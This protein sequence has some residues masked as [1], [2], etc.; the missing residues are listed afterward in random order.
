[1][2]IN[3]GINGD[4][5]ELNDPVK[6]PKA[7]GFLWN[8]SMMINANCRGYVTSQFM[9]PEPSKYSHAPNLEANTFMQPE[10][11]Y[12]KHH[13]GRFFYIK[14]EDSGDIF[15]APYEPVRSKLDSY[16]FTIGKNSINWI[17][18]K[19]DIEIRIT[20]SL[21]VEDVVELWD[22]K[23]R[24]LSKNIRNITIYPYF[25]V[26]YMSWMN[27]SGI[28]DKDLKSIICSSITPYQKY[29]EYEKIK[30]LKDKTFLIPDIAPTSW[31]VNQESFEGDGG[32][33]NPD[34]IKKDF[35][36]KGAAKYETPVCVLQYRTQLKNESVNF[37]F[38]FGPA[39][40][41]SEIL[42]IK[43]KYFRDID[44]DGVDGFSRAKEEYRDYINQANGVIKIETPDIKFNNF[45]NHWLP[46]QIY[47]HGKT[48]R[49]TTDP[50]TRNYLQDNMGMSY[51]KPDITRSAIILALNQ[52][53]KSGEMPDGILIQKSAKLKYINQIPHTDHCVW[54]PI[55][56]SAYLD[57]T[58]D[59]NIL[60]EKLPFSDS[61][62]SRTVLEHINLA[63]NWLIT[64]KDARGLNYINQG[65][66]CDPMNMVGLKG[67]GVSGWLTI[68]SA[69][70]F[71]LWS[72]ICGQFGKQDLSIK[73]NNEANK[74]NRSIN[75]YLWDGNWYARG[76]TDDNIIFGVKS[77]IEGKI[78][79]NPQSWALLSG[80]ADKEQIRKLLSSVKEDLETP[81]G[82]EMFSPAYT[83]MRE[84]IGRVTQKYPG[85]GENGSVY[86]HAAAF[87]IYGLYS[88]NEPDNAFRLLQKMIGSVNEKDTLIRGQLPV[89]I[90]NYYRGAYKQHPEMAGKSSQLFNTGTVT[91]VYKSLIDGLFGLQGC[92][93]GLKITP[94]LPSQW[95]NARVTRYFRGS[96]L[97]VDFKRDE[98]LA[99]TE[100]YINGEIITG[101]ILKG[102]EPGRKYN[103]LIKIGNI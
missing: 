77:D 38:L 4:T 24:N 16:K 46:R 86:N 70:A 85:T 10:Q 21:P 14:D 17:I 52:Q 72:E 61:D 81:F 78:Y 47:Y 25:S 11:P 30:N 31:E 56:L 64:D 66:W 54:L 2:L 76:I 93:E 58:D 98:E 39:K 40:D 80:A 41:K 22:I 75:K 19:N 35:L 34:G 42:E 103:V 68:A 84:D 13:S 97:L 79:L 94:K 32:L 74:N 62:Y 63:M 3:P 59:Y 96:E 95:N 49:L 6:M 43:R 12:Y 15:S 20:L 48:N 99:N 71:K 9:Q 5:Y 1:M 27:Q 44:K 82:V 7:S 36:E 8:E 83:S 33:S 87:Y 60:T 51:I 53:K 92:R 55:I 102:L 73:Y 23:V 26:G 50:Q 65:D 91:W 18:L 88:I 89:F 69:Y 37:R 57:E 29:Q 67:H 101:N 28:Y 45:V 90:P 100:I